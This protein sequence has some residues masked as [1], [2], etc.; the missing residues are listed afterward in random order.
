LDVAS[1]DMGCTT[2]NR[3]G[4]GLDPQSVLYYDE[5]NTCQKGEK[6]WRI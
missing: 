1:T 3:K 4:V 5:R 6:T 2:I